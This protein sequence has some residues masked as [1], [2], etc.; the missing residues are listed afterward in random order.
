[1]RMFIVAA[2]ALAGLAGCSSIEEEAAAKRYFTTEFVSGSLSVTYDSDGDLVSIESKA[3]APVTSDLPSAR[4][5]ASKV[6]AVMARKQIAEFM[7]TIVTSETVVE[8]ISSTVEESGYASDQKIKDEIVT[9]VTEQI[10]TKSQALLKG[11]YLKSETYDEQA[12]Q[13]ISIVAINS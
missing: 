6:A 11:S 10:Q 12:N 3:A 4:E 7:K 13:L 1:M 2:C 5:A 9:T 8:T